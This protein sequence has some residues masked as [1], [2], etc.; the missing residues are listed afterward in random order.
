VALAVVLPC[1][2]ACGGSQFNTRLQAF[3]QCMRAHG[4]TQ[5]PNPRAHGGFVHVLGPLFRSGLMRTPVY[6]TAVQECRHIL[7]STG[8]RPA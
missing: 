6:T 1:L 8:R 5:F 2:A 7:P 3:S 4:A